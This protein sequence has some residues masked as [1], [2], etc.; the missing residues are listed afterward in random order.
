MAWDSTHMVYADTP[1]LIWLCSLCWLPVAKNHN[2]GQILTLGD[3][4]TEPLL[5]MRAKFGTADQ[6]SMLTYQ[7]LCRLVYFVTLWRRKPQTLPFYWQH[8]VVTPVGSILRKMNT[9]AQ[10]QKFPYPTVSKS[11]CTPTFSRRNRTQK[12]PSFKSATDRQ[13]RHTNKKLNVLT[14]PSA[15]EIPAK[16]NLAWW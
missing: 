14:A 10:L 7:I 13:T 9:G 11:F 3:P 6:R 4:C 12:L 1:N 16:P 2:F 5:P 15:G 8:F